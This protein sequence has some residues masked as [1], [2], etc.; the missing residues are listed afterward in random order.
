MQAAWAWLLSICTGESDIVFGATVSGRAI[1]DEFLSPA[2]ASATGSVDTMVGMT[3]NTL[4]A[5]IKVDPKKSVRDWL[6]EIQLQQVGQ[7]IQDYN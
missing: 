5:R 7:P 1:S 4:P 6:T 2:T 3:I